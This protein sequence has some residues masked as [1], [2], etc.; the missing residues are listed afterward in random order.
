M[1]VWVAISAVGAASADT[2]YDCS[3]QGK[4][5]SHSV[6]DRVEIKY[7]G[8]TKSAEVFDA[9]VNHYFGKPIAAEVLADNTKRLTIGW[10]FENIK[11]RDGGTIPRVRMKASVLRAS[12]EIHVT[13]SYGYGDS[14]SGFGTCTVK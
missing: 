4:K 9:F 6:P 3:I 11:A 10:D 1:A 8:A 13:T 12:N 5:G 7:N 14:E 2:M